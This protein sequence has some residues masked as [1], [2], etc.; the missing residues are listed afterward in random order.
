M[1]TPQS[2]GAL[3]SKAAVASQRLPWLA[4][5]SAWLENEAILGYVLMTPALLLILVFIAYPFSL[6]VWLALTDKLVGRPANFIGLR[7]F[8]HLFESAI[9]RRTVWNTVFFTCVAT[10]LKAVLGMWLAVL[11]NRKIR[12]SRFIRATVLLPFIVPTVLSGL[13]WLW[14]KVL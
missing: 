3:A 13:A 14:M 2:S 1:T 9:F 5:L 6:G 8:T 10:T 4:T 11:L 12:F 7:N